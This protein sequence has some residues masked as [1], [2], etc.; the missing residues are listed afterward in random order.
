MIPDL[1]GWTRRF[2]D[3]NVVLHKG[4][5]PALGFIRYVERIP[6]ATPA[7][8]LEAQL[9]RDPD[10]E[11]DDASSIEELVTDEGEH[12]A[13]V[14]LRCR[15][16]GAIVQRDIGWVFGDAHV[17]RT[18]SLTP[19]PELFDEFGRTV[20]QLLVADQQHLGMRRRRYG[21][22]APEGWTASERGFAT[23]VYDAPD[24]TAQIEVSPAM[25]W[26]GSPDD[27]V[28]QLGGAS[29]SGGLTIVKRSDAT[30]VTTGRGLSGCSWRLDCAQGRTRVQR[31]SVALFDDRYSY[32]A[33]L[34][35]LDGSGEVELGAVVRSMRPVPRPRWRALTETPSVLSMWC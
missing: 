10:I 19:R 34:D 11:V 35:T 25:P 22:E 12:A 27:F 16:A 21:H 5:D 8:L 18:S 24:G 28:A 13:V 6:L 20:R 17:S 29:G 33:R 9:A 15:R 26:Q 2:I 4:G 3:G 14:T 31:T 32:L 7:E 30:P 23:L 1:A